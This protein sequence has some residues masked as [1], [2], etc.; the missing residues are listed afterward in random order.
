MELR[1]A[2]VERRHLAL[3]P[4]Q[5][6]LVLGVGESGFLTVAAREAGVY[7]I[8]ERATDGFADAL[9]IMSAIYNRFIVAVHETAL[10]VGLELQL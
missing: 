6:A 5:D 10:R 2:Q 8:V 4:F 9:K 7:F 1:A 3:A